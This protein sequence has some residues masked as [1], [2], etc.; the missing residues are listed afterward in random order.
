M[1]HPADSKYSRYNVWHC[2]WSDRENTA[3]KKQIRF[4]SFRKHLPISTLEFGSEREV[5]AWRRPP[6][7]RFR[8]HSPVSLQTPTHLFPPSVITWAPWPLW[9][10]ADLFQK[11]GLHLFGAADAGKLSPPVPTTLL[12]DLRRLSQCLSGHLAPPLLHPHLIS[13]IKRFTFRSAG[14]VGLSVP[15]L[16][17]FLLPHLGLTPAVKKAR[18]GTLVGL[19]PRK[20]DFTRVIFW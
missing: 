16:P 9:N 17:L 11:C 18:G 1:F 19:W 3:F 5:C 2:C 20:W 14:A 13:Y 10:A 7:L 6:R 8:R 15:S 12:H 4:G